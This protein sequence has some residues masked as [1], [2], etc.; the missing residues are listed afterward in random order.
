[1]FAK[2]DCVNMKTKTVSARLAADELDLLDEMARRTG[3]DRS[4]MAKALLRRGLGELRF[5]EAVVSYRA[6]QVTLSRAAEM[7]GVSIW[8]FIGR[9]GE[10]DLTFHYGVAD[11][12]EDLG[13]LG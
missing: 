4:A 6:S 2:Y 9:M 3:L 11:L 12:E 8:D 7:A 10:Q 5:D 13:G 1:M